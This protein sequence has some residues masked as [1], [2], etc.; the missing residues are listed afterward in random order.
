MDKVETH[1]T[2]WGGG[3]FRVNFYEQRL[4]I[5]DEKW[6]N[7]LAGKNAT[8]NPTKI[9][10][11]SIPIDLRDRTGLISIEIEEIVEDENKV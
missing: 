8:L 4:N 9:M 5:G 10:C 11:G 2:F 3:K 7:G 1:L 6:D